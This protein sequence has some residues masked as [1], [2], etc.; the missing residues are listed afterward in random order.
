MRIVSGKFKGKLISPPKN[1]KLRPTTDIAKESLFNIISNWYDIDDLTVLDLFAGTGSIS[2]EFISRGCISVVSVEKN[3]RHSE[4]I[5]RTV[6]DLNVSNATVIK[7]DVFLFLNSCNKTFDFIFADP[8]FD[9]ETI[10]NIPDYVFRNKLLNESGT[11]VVEH[12]SDTDFS[13]HPNFIE[14]RKYGKVNFSV[15]ENVSE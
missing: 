2:Y 8:P 11:L 1:F 9:L 5:R 14:I 6:T 13:E 3:F 4:F 7:S 10:L 12:S 15:F